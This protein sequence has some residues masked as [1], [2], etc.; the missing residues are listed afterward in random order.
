MP[1]CLA[2]SSGALRRARLVALRGS[3]DVACRRRDVRVAPHGRSGGIGVAGLAAAGDGASGTQTAEGGPPC[4]PRHRR[5]ARVALRAS[6]GQTRSVSEWGRATYGDPCRECG[7]AWSVTLDEAVAVVRAIPATYAQALG[8]AAGSERHPDL[9]WSVGSYVCHV[10][11][12][13]RIWAERLAG[14]AAGASPDVAAYDEN[15]LARARGYGQ[16]ALPAARWSLE[17]AVADWLAALDAARSAEVV[18]RHPHGGAL[19]LVD[20][21]RLNAHDALH[22]A[23]DI[24]RT[25]QR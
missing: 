20:V 21:A 23:Y 13:L 14:V 19:A 11:D 16:I 6:C 8:G 5:V 17:R 7:F 10:A 4:S 9:S 18:L 3:V 25:L 22:H 12:N 15:E 2:S 1:S 24:R